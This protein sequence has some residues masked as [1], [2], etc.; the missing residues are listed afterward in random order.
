MYSIKKYSYDRAKELGVKIQPSEKGFYKIDVFDKDNKYIT[1]IGDRRYNDFPT[2]LETKGQEYADKHRKAYH[3]RH[4]K[5]K[6]GIRG[7][8]ALNILW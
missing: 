6:E 1:S 2:F 5:S 7:F 4:N 8:Y 3:K